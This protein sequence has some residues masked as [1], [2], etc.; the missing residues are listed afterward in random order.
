MKK[1]IGRPQDDNGTLNRSYADGVDSFPGHLQALNERIENQTKHRVPLPI[2]CI[3]TFIPNT[4]RP[5]IPLERFI[6]IDWPSRGDAHLLDKIRRIVKEEDFDQ[7]RYTEDEAVIFYEKIYLL[8]T[9]VLSIGLSQPVGVAELSVSIYA[10]IFGQ[11]RFMASWIAKIANVEATIFDVSVDD[12]SAI[13]HIQDSENDLR[14]DL[15]FIDRILAKKSRYEDYLQSHPLGVKSKDDLFMTMGVTRNDGYI[16]QQLF[17][18]DQ[19]DEVIGL[20]E[21]KEITSLAAIR[22]FFQKK[23]RKEAPGGK[24]HA[25]PALKDMGFVIRTGGDFRLIEELVRNFLGSVLLSDADQKTYDN[26]DFENAEHI[27][28]AIK[29]VADKVYE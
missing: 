21:S 16:F 20:V 19:Y 15:S 17:T 5:P 13:T 18:S 28:F 2:D 29:L 3:T 7:T 8:S 11:R 10:L 25:Y 12:F 4:R 1:R 9:D 27:K 6:Q 26:L 24:K 14:S 23:K 22:S